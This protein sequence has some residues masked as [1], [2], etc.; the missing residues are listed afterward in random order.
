MI[1]QTVWLG[2]FPG[3]WNFG[4]EKPLSAQSLVHACGDLED[5][6][7]SSQLMEVWIVKFQKDLWI[8]QKHMIRSGHMILN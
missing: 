3:F 6:A 1:D 2:I 8:P 4:L 5:K 7:E